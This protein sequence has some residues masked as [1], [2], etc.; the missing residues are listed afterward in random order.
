MYIPTTTQRQRDAIRA[1]QNAR[2]DA[3]SGFWSL[4]NPWRK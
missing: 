1:G 3:M 4:L 2:A